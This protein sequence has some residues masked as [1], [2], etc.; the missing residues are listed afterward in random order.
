[1]NDLPSPET[2][3]A[4]AP[5]PAAR[6][7]ASAKEIEIGAKDGASPTGLKD[8]NFICD[9]QFIHDLDQLKA[10]RSF[11]IRQ[12]VSVRSSDGAVHL[13]ALNTLRYHPRGRWPSSDEWEK[14]EVST[15][16]L[17]H[18]LDENVRRRFLYGQIPD[19][20]TKT[21]IVLGVVSVVALV[22]AVTSDPYGLHFGVGLFLPLYIIWLAALGAVGSI[23]FLGMNALAVQTDATFDLT[24]NKLIVMRIVL[25]AL[26][27]I[28]LTIPFGFDSFIHFSSQLWRVY[29]PPSADSGWIKPDSPSDIAMQSILLL[30]PFILGFSTPLVIMILNQFVE[31]VQIFFG[32]RH[33]GLADHSATQATSGPS[34]GPVRR[35]RS[36]NA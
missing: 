22:A 9:Q 33:S 31:A 30:S 18:N 2:V 26:F 4:F 28:V 24:N 13:D 8:L 1:M 16:Q 19:W 7:G 21:A 29:S 35:R 25:G 5:P 32:K 36:S 14:L 34:L 23:S 6:Q 17:Y 3:V 12:A 11:C 20:V 27:G 10:L 15:D